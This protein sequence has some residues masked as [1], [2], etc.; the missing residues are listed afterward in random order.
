MDSHHKAL[1]ALADIGAGAA[2]TLAGWSWL[3]VIDGLL[4][5][6]L[7]IVGIAAGIAA[8]RYHT[9]M[10]HHAVEKHERDSTK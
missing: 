5:V 8:Y 6:I 4:K 7:T 2:I 1:A 9:V 10:R 3:S